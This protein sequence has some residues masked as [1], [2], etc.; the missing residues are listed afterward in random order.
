MNLLNQISKIHDNFSED[1]QIITVDY[2]KYL[3]ELEERQD[4]NKQ[5]INCLQTLEADYYFNQSQ[6]DFLLAAMD[7]SININHI[8]VETNLEQSLLYSHYQTIDSQEEINIFGPMS[9]LQLTIKLH[10]HPSYSSVYIHFP[11]TI[12]LILDNRPMT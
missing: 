7:N 10:P 3:N 8:N 2:H 4:S 9:P 11:H 5:L 6:K 12:A 1:I